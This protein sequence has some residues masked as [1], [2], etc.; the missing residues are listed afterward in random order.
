MLHN[1]SSALLY[2]VYLY[3]TTFAH[4]EGNQTTAEK[5]RWRDAA[6]KR[7][8]TMVSLIHACQVYREPG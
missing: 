4:G 5:W 2:D 3:Y 1:R 7:D 6:G 8:T